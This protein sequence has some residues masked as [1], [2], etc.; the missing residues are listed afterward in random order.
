LQQSLEEDL[1][2][3]KPEGWYLNKL[4]LEHPLVLI[5]I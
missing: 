5:I 4:L 1:I 3:K 2:T